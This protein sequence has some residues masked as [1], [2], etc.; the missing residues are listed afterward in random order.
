MAWKQ[1]SI[2][3]VLHRIKEGEITADEGFELIKTIRQEGQPA[4]MDSPDQRA[5]YYQPVWEERNLPAAARKP[6]RVLLFDT[7]PELGHRLG[8]LGVQTVLIQPGEDYARLDSQRYTLHP[9]RQ[10]DYQRLIASLKQEQALPEC[11]LHYWSREAFRAEPLQLQHQLEH[12]VYSLFYLSRALMEHQ[13]REEIKLL[14][15]YDAQGRNQPQYSGVNGLTKSVRKENPLWVYKTVEL[16]G[17]TQGTAASLLREFAA[18]DEEDDL[19]YRGNQRLV[20]TMQPVNGKGIPFSLRK[21]GN[22]LIT[23]GLGGVGYTFASYLAERTQGKLIITGRS[24]PDSEQKHRLRELE[25]W[26]AEALYIRADVSSRQEVDSLAAEARLQCAELHG[27]IHAAGI[28]KDAFLFNKSAAQM[29]EVLGPKLYGTVWLDEATRHEPLDFF[30]MFSSLMSIL[31]NA[32]QCDYTYANAFMDGYAFLRD[33]LREQGQ[34]RGKTVSINWPLWMEGGMKVDEPT[35]TFMENTMGILPISDEQGILAFEEALAQQVSQLVVL[36]ESGKRKLG[37]F[38]PESGPSVDP[39]LLAVPPVD[40]EQLLRHVSQDVKKIASEILYVDAGKIDMDADKSEYGFDSISTTDFMNRINKQFHLELTPPV[41]YEY[42]DLRSFAEFLHAKYKGTLLTLYAQRMQPAEPQNAGSAG[43]RGTPAAGPEANPA[44]AQAVSA[45][46]AVSPQ[47]PLSRPKNEPVAIIGV[48]AVMPGADNLEELWES[49]LTGKDA[50]GEIPADRWD[51]RS[52][53][54]DPV[55][56]TNKTQVKWGGFMKDIDKFDAL[57]FGISPREAELMDPRQRI[58]LETVWKVLEDAGCKPSSLSGTNTGLFVGVGS[59]DYYD[60]LNESGVELQAHIPTGVFNSILTNRISYLLNLHGPSEPIDTACS[61][62]LVAIHRAVESLRSGECR[63]AIAGGINVL[64]SPNLYISLSKAGMLSEDGRCKTFD[65][66]A[67]G[68]VR[69]EGSAALLLKPLSDAE[70]DGDPIYAVIRGSSVNH[71]GHA[72]SLTAPNP[73]AQADLIA[74]AWTKAGVD[75]SKAG[76]IEVHGSGTPLGDP[77]EINGLKKAF[78]QLY[79]ERNQAFTDEE[80]CGLGTIKTQIGHLESAAGIAGFIKVLL[81]MKH[82]KLVKNLH[83]EELNPYIDL[84]DSPFYVV[85]ETMDWK[86][87]EEGT[88]RLAGVSSFG[89]GGVNAHV[90]V[91]EYLGSSGRSGSADD[92]QLILLSAKNENRLTQYVRHLADFLANNEVRLSDLAYTL[93]TG[94]ESMEERIAIAARSVEEVKGTLALVLQ[95]ERD[96]EEVY[97]GNAKK[98]GS[99]I[100]SLMEGEE[101]RTFIHSLLE[102]RKLGPL[103]KLWL[104]GTDIPWERLYDQHVY[105]PRRISLPTYPFARERYWIPQGGDKRKTP[106]LQF[107]PIHPLV[108]Q[109]TSDLNELRFSSKFTGRE[110]FLADLQGTGRRTLLGAAHLEMARSAVG[111]AAGITEEERP[112][113]RLSDVFWGMPLE[114]DGRPADI[115]LGVY[116][117][118]DGWIGYEIYGGQDGS[119]E[120]IV[121]SR[122]RAAFVQGEPGQRRDLSAL[123]A[124]CS[125]R[126]VMSAAYY[127]ALERRGLFYEEGH[128]GIEQIHV[129]QEQALAQLSLPAVWAAD[130]PAYVLHPCIV[131]AALSV[132]HLWT[133]GQEKGTAAS[134][135]FGPHALEEMEVYRPC[136][137]SMWA[138]VRPSGGNREDGR[139]RMDIEMYDDQGTVCIR[140]RGFTL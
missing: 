97:R 64:T 131:E 44:A 76:Y 119:G 37:L 5:A 17:M 23:G 16:D 105:Q 75:P 2:D 118:E 39:G 65:K 103:A 21:K 98:S 114:V 42:P 115:H 104:S 43:R 18:K 117:E 25:Q 86:R 110:R 72:N 78:G 27:V 85:K 20:K 30:V 91:E 46:R 73:N 123:Q 128:R 129:G 136:T 107:E 45:A 70:R 58:Y 88:A 67:N 116:R 49:L 82:G 120:S 113:L 90:V 22:Y 19:L 32:G 12:G 84:K 3:R 132:A 102:G 124:E 66:K 36:K 69:G 125:E 111:Q 26:G 4:R 13:A 71:G 83:F 40:A 10:E 95:G 34:R 99:L 28:V 138:Q 35:L 133:M 100:G 31:G 89:F 68:Y 11:I 80:R 15:I 47:D 127:E 94:R 1:W 93:Q 126:T 81:C 74:D 92:P 55:K 8:S 63:L 137:S 140:M 53:Y 9:S 106:A 60:L 52:Y 134:R 122:G 101:G 130:Q 41:F 29:G 24:E 87:A 51:W 48:S 79:A 38:H 54:G 7:T 139:Q 6:E 77:I 14:Y 56:E 50:I 109:N 135:P 121:Y 96:V 57:F 59:S 62:S 33:G 108:H 61:S 112:S